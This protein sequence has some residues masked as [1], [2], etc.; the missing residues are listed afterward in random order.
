MRLVWLVVLCALV[1]GTACSAAQYSYVDL[2]NRL[3]D[4]EGLAVL[5]AQGEICAQCSSYDRASRYDAATGKYV[6][7]DANGD[8]SG[9]VRIEDGKQVFGEIEG[10]GCIWR[11]WSAAPKSG[12]VRIYLDGATEPTIDLPFSGYFDGRNEPFTYSALVHDAASGKNC[13]VPIPFQKS[14]KIVADP[15]WGAYYHFTYSIFP[16]DTIVPTF[17]RELAPDEAAALDRVNRFLAKSLGTDPAKRQVTNVVAPVVSLAPGE[18]ATVARIEGPNAI[19]CLRAAINAKSY[20]AEEL[21]SVVLKIYWDGEK[22]PSVWSPLGDFFGTGLGAN[23]YKSL[24]MGVTDTDAYSYWYMPFAK[25]AVV[26]LENQSKAAFTVPFYISYSP[27][28]KP[29]SELGRFHAKWHRD[30]FLPM[31]PERWIDW[32]MLKTEGRG[33]FCGVMLEVWNPGGGWWGEGD[34]KFWVDGEKFPSTFGTGSEDYFGYAWCN[35][36]LFQN[37]YHNQTRND[38]NNNAGHVSVNR[39]HITD[40]VPFQTSFEADIEKYF[41]NSRHTHYASIAY[42]Y[43]APGGKDPYGEIGSADRLNWYERPARTTGVLEGEDLM[44]I[45]KTAGNI[46]IQ[47]LGDS[48]SMGGH[49]WWT[50]AKPGDELNLALPVAKSGKYELKMSFTKAVDYGIIQIMLDGK[51]AG[52]PID[53]YNNGVVAF[54]PVSL[55]VFELTKGRHQLSAE[56]VGANEK[57]IKSYMFGLDYVRL[58]PVK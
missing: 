13:Y 36:T 42:W 47:A 54:G 25:E 24:P 34:E 3:T 48:W 1:L 14:C 50:G 27:L 17:K 12:H 6:G 26:E 51:K 7:W 15:D 45:S 38:N 37:A 20:S 58:T 11:I 2:V 5:P 52:N 33:R 18:T 46:S 23:S 30:A 57:A 44:V 32:P 31:E 28:D 22:N 8:G 53:F 10:P 19:T 56:I 41:R 43:L 9:I 49:L 4:L 35:P 40:N 21:R 29:I 39:W 16:K 55:G